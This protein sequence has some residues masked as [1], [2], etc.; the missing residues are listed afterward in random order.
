MTE[1]SNKVVLVTGASS[2][3]GEATARELAGAGATVVIGARRVERRPRRRGWS[4]WSSQESCLTSVRR[5][6]VQGGPAF[7]LD[8]A[9]QAR[10]QCPPSR[11]H[12]DRGKTRGSRL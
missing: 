11:S 8:H 7:D 10:R 3:I 4:G 5:V 1:I 12:D 2:G 9:P 6:Q